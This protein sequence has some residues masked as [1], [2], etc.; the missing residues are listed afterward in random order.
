MSMLSHCIS[1]CSSL[2]TVLD[3]STP[4]ASPATFGDAVIIVA[5]VAWPVFAAAASSLALT[6]TVRRLVPSAVS[7]VTSLQCLFLAAFRGQ[8]SLRKI[9]QRN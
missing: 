8:A 3:E 9:V 1:R 5:V 6:P 2:V 7:T 4:A